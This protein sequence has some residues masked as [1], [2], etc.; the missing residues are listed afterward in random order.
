MRNTRLEK[1]IEKTTPRFSTTLPLTKTKVIYRPFLVKEEKVLLITLGDL[2]EN[3][4]KGR[5]RA[6]QLIIENCT[7]IENIESLLL[8]EVDILFLKIRSKSVNNV[9]TVNYNENETGKNHSFALDLEDICI[10]GDIPDPKVMLTENMGVVLSMPTFSTFMNSE[11]TSE[12]GE[13][14]TTID[15]IVNL[16]RTTIVEI[17]S[18]DIS[19][20][21]EDMSDD[22]L[23]N[24]LNSL[25]PSHLEKMAAYF[26]KMPRIHKEMVYDVDGEESNVVL[27][28]IKDLLAI[29]MSHMTLAAYYEL[30]FAL[31]H[32]H[33]YSLSDIENMIPWEREVY[34]GYLKSTLEEEKR[35]NE[36]SKG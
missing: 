7:D 20:K 31:M 28:N 15:E 23:T 11:I 35:A 19:I 5:Y 8:C 13:D 25:S 26:A 9:V 1:I 6:I 18:D 21:R 29:S 24:F 36:Q 3:D 2:H 17:F 14:T 27:S 22:D 12:D 10:V 30:T 4:L 34:L 32:H 33:K 16:V